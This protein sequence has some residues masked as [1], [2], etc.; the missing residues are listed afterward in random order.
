MKCLFRLPE[1]DFV[2]QLVGHGRRKIC[3]KKAN[4][5]QNYPVPKNCQDIRALY[6]LVNYCRD[7][8]SH[9]SSLSGPLTDLTTKRAKFEWMGVHQSAFDQIKD[10]MANA[11]EIT[12]PDPDRPFV[13]QTHASDIGLGAAL[14]QPNG[15]GVLVPVGS[16]SRKL[17]VHER[18]YPTR[19]KEMLAIVWGLLEYRHY[20]EGLP[21]EVQ[22]DHSAL[23]FINSMGI[24]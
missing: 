20:I 7:F 14:F 5:I 3:P 10:L 18:N 19:E 15:T 6:G 22:T 16:S 8:L 2:G 13:L 9:L 17:N 11:I 21:I 12:I 24:T 4:L 23:R 1:I